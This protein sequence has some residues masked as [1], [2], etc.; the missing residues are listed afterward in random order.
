MPIAYR[1]LFTH[2]PRHFKK[3]LHH[4]LVRGQHQGVFQEPEELPLHL[5][6]GSNLLD[7]VKLKGVS[8][9]YE[10]EVQENSERRFDRAS[11]REVACNLGSQTWPVS[12]GR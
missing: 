6:R 11:S 9:I 3:L 1:T 7:I 5:L 2:E 8:G 12:C 4:P 10:H